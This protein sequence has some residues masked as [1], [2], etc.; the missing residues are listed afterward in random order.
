VIGAPAVLFDLFETLFT[1]Y[2]HP[3][4]PRWGVPSRELGLD[5]VGFRHAWMNLQERRMTTPLTY[6]EAL[7]LICEELGCE[8][9]PGAIAEL[10]EIRCRD[11][12]ACFS[13]LDDAVVGALQVLR[14]S[15][16][17]TAIVSNCSV[18]EITAFASSDIATLV[19]DVVW[20]FAVGKAKPDPAIYELACERLSVT[21]ADAVFVGDGSFGE[22]A[23]AAEA[24]LRPI[25]ASW[26]ITRWPKE[27]AAARR[28]AMVEGGFPEASSPW[29]LIDL[30]VR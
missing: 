28:S 16:T 6:A 30:L 5:P 2:R 13:E 24:G 29:Q 27:L 20:S 18:E 26:F 9:P 22:L 23:G 14:T 3:T 4:P 11:K 19:D 15:G 25:W 1:E 7:Q 17:A 8:P 12:A 10:D 21:P